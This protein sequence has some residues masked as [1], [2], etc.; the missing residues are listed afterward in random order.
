MVGSILEIQFMRLKE[1]DLWGNKP[2]EER[3]RI[4]CVRSL[5]DV[6]FQISS[7]SF[8]TSSRKF[9][10]ED[11]AKDMLSMEGLGIKEDVPI[12]W[13]EADE[14]RAMARTKEATGNVDFDDGKNVVRDSSEAQQADHDVVP[15]FEIIVDAT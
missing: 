4:C 3:S 14:R 1:S 13:F 12:S 6:D 5:V 15:N 7:L 2:S 11:S 9:S 10:E 8:E